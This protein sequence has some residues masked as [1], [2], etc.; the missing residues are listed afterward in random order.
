MSVNIGAF[1]GPLMVGHFAAAN[2]Y[3]AAFWIAG[4]GMIIGL[5]TFILGYKKFLSGK[6][7]APQD[8]PVFYKDPALWAIVL[9]SR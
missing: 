8:K 9:A 7:A 3:K 5:L 6:G 4:A 1:F 2:N